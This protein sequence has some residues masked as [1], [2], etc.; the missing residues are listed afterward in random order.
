MRNVVSTYINPDMDGTALMYS[1]TEYLRKKGF[2]A[3]YYYEGNLK[4]EAELVL[5]KFNIEFKPEKAIRENDKFILVDTN[6]LRYT[7]KCINENNVIEIIDHHRKEGWDNNNNIKMQ[8]EFVGAASTLVAEKFYYENIEITRESAILL[9]YGIISNTMNLK[10]KMTTSRDIKMANWLKSLVKE[11]SDER[12]KEIFIQKSQIGNK[13]R[14]EME[15]EF[16]DEFVSIKW[17][18]GQLEVANVNEFLQKHEKE[19]IDIMHRV[20][21]EN[22][23]EFMSVNCMDILNGYTIILSMNDKTKKIIED[24][25]SIKFV[26]NKARL[27]YLI[28]RKEIV[29]VIREVFK[30]SD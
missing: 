7:P 12:T 15:I 20:S 29:K 28:S 13:L 19:I 14:E 24:A 26:G 30:K 21:D 8:I 5:N 11:I 3:T 1:Y 2:E 16:K 27:D 4:R 23:V 10:I 9:Y 25:V 6:G 17:S 18:M 22:D